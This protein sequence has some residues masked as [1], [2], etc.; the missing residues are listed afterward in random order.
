M[1]HCILHQLNY[2]NAH[3]IRLLNVALTHRQRLHL[4]PDEIEF[5]L[6]SYWRQLNADIEAG[7]DISSGQA[8]ECLE[9]AIK[10]IIGYKTNEDFLLLLRRLSTQV[11]QMARPESPAQHTALQNVLTLLA[12]FAKCSLSSVKGAVSYPYLGLEA[13]TINGTSLCPRCSTSTLS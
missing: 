2:R 1:S 3:A 11:E 13:I 4:D 12:L 9:P 6:S 8:L 7:G 5:V 10:L